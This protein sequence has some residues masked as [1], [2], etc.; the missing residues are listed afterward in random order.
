MIGSQIPADQHDGIRHAL[1]DPQ[2]QQ[3]DAVR[4]GIF[5]IQRAVGIDA[6]IEF[7]AQV[8]GLF[9]IENIKI[10][11]RF[12]HGDHDQRKRYKKN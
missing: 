1:I 11:N 6:D 2:H 7:L 9:R 3:I 8:A 5:R 12:Q 4:A 10:G